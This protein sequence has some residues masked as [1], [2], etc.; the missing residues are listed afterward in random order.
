MVRVDFDLVE[1]VLAGM[2][3]PARRWQLVTWAEFNAA[4]LPV[5]DALLALPD[6]TYTC[7]DD[8]VRAARNDSEPINLCQHRRHPRSCPMHMG[9]HWPSRLAS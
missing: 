7:A 9:T 5:I 4:A 6:T 2:E 8:V 3:Y 1:S